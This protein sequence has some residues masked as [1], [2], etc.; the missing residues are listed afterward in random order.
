MHDWKRS[1]WQ[2]KGCSHQY[3]KK[4]IVWIPRGMS[5]TAHRSARQSYPPCVV[6]LTT[7]RWGWWWAP[8]SGWWCWPASAAPPA[9]GAW[10]TTPPTEDPPDSCPPTPS[11]EAGTTLPYLTSCLTGL[12][13]TRGMWKWD[14]ILQIQQN[15]FK[16]D[17]S[18]SLNTDVCFD[19]FCEATTRK[20]IA[21]SRWISNYE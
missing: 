10:S 5:N 13:M 12:C 18:V 16:N 21:R 15:R 20:P 2:N 19:Y 1:F 3:L 6:R 7:W 4:A 14:H 8:A 9:C 17:L 11:G